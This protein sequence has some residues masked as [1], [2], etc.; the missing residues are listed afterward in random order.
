MQH[1][2]AFCCRIFARLFL[3][4]SV[5]GIVSCSGGVSSLNPVT[6]KVLY[7][8]VPA[9][10]VLVAFHLVGGDLKSPVPTGFTND[11]GVFE[12]ETGQVPGAA[13][14]E[15]IVTMTWNVEPPGT[16]KAKGVTT[17]SMTS[18]VVTVDKLKGSYSDVKNSKLP[19][20][21]IKKGVNTL[22]PPFKLQ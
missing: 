19:H 22:D 5:L 16:K 18:E 11:D 15:Y 13:A 9:G 14:G 20:V 12:I 2:G 4:L 7:K 6:G 10:G 21:T 8:D 17:M 1:S 3:L